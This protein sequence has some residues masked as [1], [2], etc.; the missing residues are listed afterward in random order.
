MTTLVSLVAEMT[1]RNSRL[2]EVH[3]RGLITDHE[4]A[5]EL[6]RIVYRFTSRPITV[7]TTPEGKPVAVETPSV[8]IVKHTR[9]VDPDH[10]AYVGPADGPERDA[11]IGFYADQIMADIE[12]DRSAGRFD[13]RNDRPFQPVPTS[14]GELHSWV[15]ANEYMIRA[16]VPWTA[17]DD[18]QHTRAFY[19]DVQDEVTVRLGGSVCGC[20]RPL[21]FLPGSERWMS[22]GEADD[23]CRIGER[24]R[25]YPAKGRGSDR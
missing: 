20:G 16:D 1:R 4:F 2:R 7:S 9:A 12:E 14:F 5:E 15:D 18:D 6:Q 11:M 21:A 19:A 8:L 24:G 25:H 22:T 3:A 23:V 13:P 17:D 10:V